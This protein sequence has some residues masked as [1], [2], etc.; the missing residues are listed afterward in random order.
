MKFNKPL[1]VNDSIF[2]VL[3]LEHLANCSE[4]ATGILVGKW[5]KIIIV[6]GFSDET[7]I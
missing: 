7:V 5:K 2:S 1:L 4:E 6:N 3:Q